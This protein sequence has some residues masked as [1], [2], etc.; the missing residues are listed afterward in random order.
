MKK[1]AKK[2]TPSLLK[3]SGGGKYVALSPQPIRQF[4]DP[5]DERFSKPWLFPPASW[6]GSDAEYAVE[7]ALVSLK[8]NHVFQ[9]RV[10]SLAE[11]LGGHRV[12]FYLPDRHIIIRVQVVYFHYQQGRRR[13]AQIIEYDEFQKQFLEQEGFTT[14]DIDSDD[15]LREPIYY[16]KEQ[17]AP[18][19]GKFTDKKKSWHVTINLDG[20]TV[21]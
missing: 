18:S 20:D 4:I 13:D 15:A 7:W 19:L 5:P 6:E 2:T 10:G 1:L 3:K 14:I 12:D 21:S 9:F 11:Q 16:T 8:E 17:L